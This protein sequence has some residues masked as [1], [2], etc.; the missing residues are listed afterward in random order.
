VKTTPSFLYNDI[1]MYSNPSWPFMYHITPVK[2]LA[3]V[4]SEGLKIDSPFHLTEGGEWAA[5]YYGL[6]Y[7]REYLNPV[8]LSKNPWI[9]SAQTIAWGDEDKEPLEHALLKVN[10]ADLDLVADL[11]SLIDK[12]A[13]SDEGV[14]W[15]KRDRDIPELLKDYHDSEYGIDIESLL[16]PSSDV[17]EAAIQTTQTAACLQ[18]ISPDR[19]EFVRLAF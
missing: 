18:N 17:A 2:N 15:W 12:G 6:A 11:P 19:I 5:D 3:Q 16:E 4:L 13:Y 1:M 7:D 14:I 8:Y 9:D 10:I